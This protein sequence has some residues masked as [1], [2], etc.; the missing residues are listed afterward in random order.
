MP[1]ALAVSRPLST[2]LTPLP[3]P[4]QHVQLTNWVKCHV[5]RP[6]PH[7]VERCWHGLKPAFTPEGLPKCADDVSW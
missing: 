7:F 5:G 4:S 1:Q 3:L 6:R 2:P